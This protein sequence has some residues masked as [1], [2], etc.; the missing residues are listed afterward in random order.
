MPMPIYR[1]YRAA[2]LAKGIVAM[3]RLWLPCILLAAFASAA[4]AQTIVVKPNEPRSIGP[5]V[6]EQ[7]RI[8]I[9]VNMFVAAPNDDSEQALKVQEDGRRL[10]YEVA[11]REC[12]ILRDTLASDCRLDAININVQRV[13]ASQNQNFGARNDGFNINGNVTFRVVPK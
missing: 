2:G 3:K 1:R 12:V 8:S 11:G 7:V 9:A 10:I 4:P 6:A 5:I 13:M